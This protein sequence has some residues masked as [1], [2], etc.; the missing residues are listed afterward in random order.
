VSDLCQ[1][2]TV[3]GVS[4]LYNGDPLSICDGSG[5]PAGSQCTPYTLDGARLT[6][7][8]RT[9]VTCS[10]AGATSC[11]R[12]NYDGDTLVIDGSPLVVCTTVEAE[13]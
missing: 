12:F 1:V 2:L 8:G 10:D 11:A 3:N 5:G 13:S 6:V 9:L 7:G 4:F